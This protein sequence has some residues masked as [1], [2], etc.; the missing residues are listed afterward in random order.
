MKGLF[1]FPVLLSYLFG[2]PAFAD[3]QKGLDA[4]KSGDY[5]TALKEWKPLADQGHAVAQYN[6]GIGYANGKGVIQDYKGALK[7]FKL[8]AKQGH[9]EAQYNL[10]IGYAK[11]KGVIQDYKGALKW[12]KLAAK[13]GHAKAQYNLGVGY[14]NGNGVIQ[15]YTLA[16]MWINIA[17]SQANVNWMKYRDIIAEKMTPSQIEKAQQLAQECEAKNYKGC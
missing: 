16:H 11:G 1:I 17:A 4:Y 3:I 12:F 6:L 8:A 10:G 15:D 7:W 13:Q 5:A 14:A 2:I 9:A